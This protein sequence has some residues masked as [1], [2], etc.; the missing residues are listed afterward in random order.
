MKKS[1]AL[2]GCLALMLTA[3]VPFLIACNEC[4][5][6]GLFKPCSLNGTMVLMESK[7]VRIVELEDENGNIVHDIVD[8]D[9]ADDLE[10][11]NAE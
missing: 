10:G 5:L 8:A 11:V 7:P 1:A 9:I 4:G 6:S 3:V 2:L